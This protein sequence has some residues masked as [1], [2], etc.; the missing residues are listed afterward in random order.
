MKINI[1]QA[2]FALIMLTA[3]ALFAGIHPW[4]VFGVVFGMV[5]LTAISYKMKQLNPGSA[6]LTI[7]IPDFTVKEQS[8]IEKMSAEEFDNY[9]Q[10][11]TNYESA[12]RRKETMDMIIELKKENGDNEKIKTLEDRMEKLISENDHILLELK[13]ERES[14]TKT[15]PVGLLKK[16]EEHADDL[17]A[18]KEG[19]RKE[20]KFDVD[21]D[22]IKAQQNPSDIGNRTDFAQMLPGIDKIPH[23]RVYIKGRIKV[24]PTS[25]EYIKYVDQATVVRDA[26]N[27]AQCGTTT[28]NTKLTWTTRNMQITKTRD[29]VDICIDMLDD[30]SFIE[31]EIRE[32]V[33]S[34]LQLKIDSDLL[35]S[36]AVYPNPNSIAGYS[37]TF[38]AANVAA[39]YAATIQ[40]ATIIDLI[41]VAAAQISAFGQENFFLA[42]TVYMNPK[43]YTLMT[44]LKD[45]D[46]NYIKGATVDPRV[47]QDRSGNVWINGN[48]L[49]LPNPN[50]TA[51]EF[52]IFDSTKATIYQ[53]KNA[54]VEFSYENATNFEEDVVTVK[55]TERYNMLVKNNQV[56]AFMHVP[57]IAAA[58][59]AITV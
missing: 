30:Y 58:I 41:V 10:A 47:F 1:R 39:P 18:M 31:G 14:G 22:T 36:D 49:V 2:V 37:S 26:K 15:V 48:V 38:N 8:E 59:T 12:V 52:Y 51:N 9:M 54:T 35:T 23:R 43:D 4:Q 5:A 46:D 32:L 40:A 27:V 7:E 11:K 50:V 19:K 33:T 45:A 42:D 24:Q 6:W 34:S 3:A 25:K 17:K 56:N 16:L 20:L 55:A 44:L 21:I 13:K 29:L 57:D 53:R 28:H